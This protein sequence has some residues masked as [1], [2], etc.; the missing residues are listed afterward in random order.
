MSTTDNVGS[1]TC[2]IMM[3]THVKI[4]ASYDFQTC[5]LDKYR[6][7]KLKI[8]LLDKYRSYR[9]NILRIAV[10]CMYFFIFACRQKKR[11]YLF[12]WVV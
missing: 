11:L 2:E 3:I 10:S 7:Y 1:L 4:N 6:S 12:F 8:C 5:L 9:L